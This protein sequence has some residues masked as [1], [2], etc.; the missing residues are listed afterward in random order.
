MHQEPLWIEEKASAIEVIRLFNSRGLTFLP[1]LR[2]GKVVGIISYRDVREITPSKTEV[3]D[4]REL[5]YLL[6]KMTA[7]DVMKPAAA[8][9]RP[10]DTIE[11]DALR[12]LEHTVEA[13]AVVDSRN[14]LVG[15]ITEADVLRVLISISG[16]GQGGVQ[17]G[18]R[19]SQETAGIEEV[20]RTIKERGG[21]IMSIL[22]A[23]DPEDES[24]R[25][26]F[27]RIGDLEGNR[28]RGLLAALRRKFNVVSVRKDPKSVCLPS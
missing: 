13:L 18:I 2:R 1:V 12:M 3:M 8:K 17:I 10:T 7:G 20:T 11:L 25:Q 9:V 6:S 4:I 14:R 19:L 5:N 21:R 22:G 27:I 16:I 26:V 24:S 28:L 15:I 23:R